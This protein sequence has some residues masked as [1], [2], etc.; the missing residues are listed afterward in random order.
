MIICARRTSVH[1]T[2]IYTS[3]CL[4]YVLIRIYIIY[5]Y[6]LW[7]QLTRSDWSIILFMSRGVCAACLYIVPNILLWVLYAQSCVL[8]SA[9]VDWR[10]ECVYILS[11]YIHRA[12]ACLIF[13]VTSC[14]CRWRRR[15]VN[16]SVYRYVPMWHCYSV[17]Y[18]HTHTHTDDDDNDNNN[19][20]IVTLLSAANCDVLIPAFQYFYIFAYPPYYVMRSRV[21]AGVRVTDNPNR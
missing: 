12:R 1:N 18:A 16:P 9:I 4:L 19:N 20:N 13:L 6:A 21:Y 11:A 10:I 17:S 7:H 14:S 3:Q 5:T 8:L 2:I 15:R